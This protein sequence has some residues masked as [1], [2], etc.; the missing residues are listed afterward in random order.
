MLKETEC[1][2]IITLLY[3]LTHRNLTAKFWYRQRLKETEDLVLRG[4]KESIHLVE[5]LAETETELATQVKSM[6]G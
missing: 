3:Y 5:K 2:E 6:W 4:R 1:V